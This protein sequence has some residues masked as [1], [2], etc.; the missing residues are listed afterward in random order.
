MTASGW[1]VVVVR[2][3]AA[4]ERE[5]SKKKVEKFMKQKVAQFQEAPTHE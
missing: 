2:Q 3:E 4:Q 1:Q 5:R